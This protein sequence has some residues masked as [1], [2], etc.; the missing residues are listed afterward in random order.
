MTTITDNTITQGE[1]PEFYAGG[2]L[3]AKEIN[4]DIDNL[5]AKTK[6][7]FGIDALSFDPGVQ[8]IIGNIVN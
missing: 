1:P 5:D 8:G 4:F 6:G 7:S 3:K 2:Q